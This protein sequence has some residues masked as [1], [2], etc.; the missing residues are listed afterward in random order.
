METNNNSKNAKKGFH[1]T[2]KNLDTGK[3]LFDKDTKAIIGAFQS[4]DII[5]N[6]GLATCNPGLLIETIEAAENCINKVKEKM[7][8]QLP[9]EVI[10]ALLLGGKKHE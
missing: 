9:L 10:M 8:K 6:L 1:I 3:V 7:V 4:G 5:T 2:I